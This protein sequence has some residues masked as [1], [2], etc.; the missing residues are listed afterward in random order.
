M[1]QVLHEVE[2]LIIRGGKR[3]G[4]ALSRYWPVV[5]PEANSIGETNLT[6]YL[7]H[8]LLQLGFDIYPEASHIEVNGRIDLLAFGELKGKQ[9]VSLYVE[10]KR[11]YNQEKAREILDD[12][13][14][15]NKFRVIDSNLCMEGKRGNVLSDARIGIIL[16]LTQQ[17]DYAEWWAASEEYGPYKNDWDELSRQLSNMDAVT[18]SFP[19]VGLYNLFV[20]YH[21]FPVID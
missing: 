15:I 12:Y 1:T 3:M 7:G 17:H 20:L 5:N 19:L 10:A 8:E 21:I 11:L 4:Q 16:A 9:P 18:G 13:Q 14:R 2:G 6:A